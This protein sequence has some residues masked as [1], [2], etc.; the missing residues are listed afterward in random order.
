[1]DVNEEIVVN[2]LNLCKEQFTIENIRFKVF[3]PKGGSNYSDIDILAV[4]KNGK[5]YD[6]EIKWRSVYSLN[7]TD[8]E[9]L[10]AFINQMLRKERV[11]KIKEI[12]GKKQYEKI[13]ITTKRL[14]GRS[15][16]KR[17]FI[18]KEFKKKGIKII[19]FEELINEL[20]DKI[21]IKGRY[22]SPI[23]QTI[24]MLKYFEKIKE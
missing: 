5:Y 2:W 24:R 1:M 14:F 3:G 19:Y 6:Y 11:E 22:D 12:I 23:L 8:G 13:F 16:E 20:V 15:S 4:D 10:E 9:T 7:A 17:N 21:E 18:E